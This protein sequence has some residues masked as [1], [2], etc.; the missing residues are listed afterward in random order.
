ML[1][2]ASKSSKLVG[3]LDA[4]DALDG[5]DVA[6]GVATDV[7][8]AKSGRGSGS[9]SRAPSVTWTALVN[10]S[11]FSFQTWVRRS[12]ELGGAGANRISASSTENS[13]ADTTQP[14]THPDTN[15][16]R[17]NQRTQVESR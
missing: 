16:H 4:L 13:V 11:V 2:R 3:L 5:M 8:T 9:A 12:S 15:A 14:T 7:A 6:T 1:P 17:E 10:G